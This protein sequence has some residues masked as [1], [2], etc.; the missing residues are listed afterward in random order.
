VQNRRLNTIEEQSEG[1]ALEEVL[2]KC[3]TLIIRRLD[4]DSDG[5]TKKDVGGGAKPAAQA[6]AEGEASSPN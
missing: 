6:A 2:D 5:L 1:R 4:Q 3:V